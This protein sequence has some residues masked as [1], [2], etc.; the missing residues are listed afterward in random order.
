MQPPFA[1]ARW[2]QDAVRDDLRGYVAAALGGPDGMPIG[3]DTGFEKGGSCAAG[4]AAV[5]VH[6]REGHHLPD[7]GLP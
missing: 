5:H 7:R 4:T 2:D 1:T 6:S 3:D